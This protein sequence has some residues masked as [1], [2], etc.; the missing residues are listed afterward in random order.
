MEAVCAC[1]KPCVR[2][3]GTAAVVARSRPCRTREHVRS[4]RWGDLRTAADESYSSRLIR[5]NISTPPTSNSCPPRNVS[6][7]CRA[8]EQSVELEGLFFQARPAVSPGQVGDAREARLRG[9]GLWDVG[10]G[11][12]ELRAGCVGGK[13][14]RC[15][16]SGSLCIGLAVTPAGRRIPLLGA[17]TGP[18]RNASCC[19]GTL[20]LSLSTLHFLPL[21]HFLLSLYRASCDTPDPDPATPQGDPPP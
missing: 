14:I 3:S 5:K 20:S 7:V 21:S 18:R 11:A 1:L 15:H 2:V 19:R 16:I 10:G 9:D 17:R 8:R 13:A 6:S 12:N 4:A